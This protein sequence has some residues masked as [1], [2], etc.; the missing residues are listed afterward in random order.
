MQLEKWKKTE[1]QHRR[2][3]SSARWAYRKILWFVTIYICL[4][5]LE[6]GIF[7]KTCVSLY[8]LHWA[9]RD[10]AFGH[11]DIHGGEDKDRAKAHPMDLRFVAS[12]ESLQ[13]VAKQTP[14]LDVTRG[15]QDGSLDEPWSGPVIDVLSVGTMSRPQYLHAQLSTWAAHRSVRSFWGFTEQQDHNLTCHEMSSREVIE[16]VHKCRAFEGWSDSVH[17]FVYAGFG[18]AEGGVFESNEH[19]DSGW[20]CA[21]RRIGRAFGWLEQLFAQRSVELPDFLLLVVGL[22]VEVLLLFGF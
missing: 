2:S 14:F 6:D 7:T 18:V 17:R 21:Q 5:L 1:R 3:R 9:F 4:L 20:F 12:N 16:H 19:Q 15:D 8:V 22:E 10:A 11:G 13:A